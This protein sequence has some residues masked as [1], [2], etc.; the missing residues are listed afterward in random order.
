MSSKQFK[1]HVPPNKKAPIK[2]FYGGFVPASPLFSFSEQYCRLLAINSPS[3]RERSN[4]VHALIIFVYA[5]AVKFICGINSFFTREKFFGHKPLTA[6]VRENVVCNETQNNA[7]EKRSLQRKVERYTGK[8]QPT[9]KRRTIHRK[10]SLQ[11]NVERCTRRTNNPSERL[12]LR[13]REEGLFV[14]RSPCSQPFPPL[15]IAKQSP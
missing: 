4:N 3:K 6:R 1:F 13:P 15:V 11:R 10:R 7:L 9:T 5:C 2:P 12:R 14:L 8:T